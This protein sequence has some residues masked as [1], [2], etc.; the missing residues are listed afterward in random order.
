MT[1]FSCVDVLT[2]SLSQARA[3]CVEK[4]GVAPEC[5]VS[6]CAVTLRLIAVESHF[7]FV[8]MELAKNAMRYFTSRRLSPSPHPF[9]LFS[10]LHSSYDQLISDFELCVVHPTEP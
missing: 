6:A 2:D 8:V 10:L 1:A 9:L 5:R 3:F 7:H 4:Y